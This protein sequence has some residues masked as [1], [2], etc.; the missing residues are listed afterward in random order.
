M[1]GGECRLI[2][3]GEQVKQRNFDGLHP[4]DPIR[5]AVVSGH[6]I[7]KSVWCAW[8]TH[9]IMSTRPRAKGTVTANT[10]SQLS[11]KTWAAIQQWGRLLI[12][13]HWFTITADMMYFRGHKGIMGSV[14]T[15]L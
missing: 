10:F 11:T 12:N 4:V 3:L 14:R 2:E 13:R 15:E 1:Q 6:G 9:W 8:V 5:I 7:G